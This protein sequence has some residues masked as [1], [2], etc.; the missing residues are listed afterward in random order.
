MNKKDL[1]KLLEELC[2]KSSKEEIKKFLF[3]VI[4]K[5]SDSQNNEII[6]LINEN[7]KDE[8]Q[9]INIDDLDK[10]IEKIEAQFDLIND[11][12]LQFHCETYET[13]DYDCFGDDY[14][15]SYYDY[16]NISSIILN[17]YNLASI[18]ITKNDYRN[19]KKILDLIVLTNYFILEDD[20]NDISTYEIDDIISFGLVDIDINKICLTLLFITILISDNKLEEI[21]NYYYKLY[22]FRNIKLEDSF[23]LGLEKIKDL[24][25]FLQNWIQFLSQKNDDISFNLLINYLEYSNFDNYKKV[26]EMN[27][28]THPKLCIFILKK[29]YDLKKYKEVIEIGESIINDVDDSIRRD[30][31]LLIAESYK[32][33]D[34]D[35]DI[36]ELLYIAFESSHNESDLIRIINNDYLAKYKE[37]IDIIKEDPY[38]NLNGNAIV[39]FSYFLGEFDVFL[40]FFKDNQNY[41]GWT[42]SNMNTYV[43]LMLFLLC[44]WNET[45]I[46]KKLASLI[47]F[48][49]GIKDD[50]NLYNADEKEIED[51][52]I[53]NVWKKH[54]TISDKI[55]QDYISWLE[56]AIA[57]R[58]DAIVYNQHRGSYHKAAFLVCI[59]DE[60]LENLNIK[61][62]GDI[63]EFY[64]KKYLKYNAFRKEINKLKISK[65]QTNMSKK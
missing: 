39:L 24:D 12:Q 28:I 56:E 16:E 6:E 40:N 50:Y 19:A 27:K 48:D 21:Y 34:S 43:E 13:G 25:I 62:K 38:K 33:F 59:L 4:E 44:D 11:G 64:E 65:I 54:F 53:L 52:K 36:S 7:F 15:T 18:L 51:F 10:T 63:I 58:V 9:N 35:F 31:A 29:I 26:L 57:K 5:L 20:S 49:I 46:K 60:C 8:M 37:E 17:T 32:K 14:E 42:Y 41:L 55:R 45:E 2:E 1:Y 3:S 47:C 23:S 61:N 22:V 30:I